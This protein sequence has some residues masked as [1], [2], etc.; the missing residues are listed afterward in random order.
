[1]NVKVCEGDLDV[2]DGIKNST[3]VSKIVTLKNLGWDENIS[4]FNL[5]KI[6]GKPFAKEKITVAISKLANDQTAYEKTS[7]YSVLKTSFLKSDYAVVLE[8]AKNP[9]IWV[10]NF[11]S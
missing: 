4:V 8:S 10:Q 5:E 9:K 6:Y 1:V 7:T 2:I 11:A 3:C